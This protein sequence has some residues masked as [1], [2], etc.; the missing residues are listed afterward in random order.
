L[1]KVPLKYA[2][3]D[4]TELAISE[5]QERMA[6]VVTAADVESFLA[7]AS[8]ENLEAVAVAEVTSEA[9]LVLKWRGKKIVDLSRAFLDTNGARQ[10]AQVYV[11]IPS[12]SDN[13]KTVHGFNG[14]KTACSFN[15]WLSTLAALN[16]CSQKGLVEMFDSTIGCGTVTLPYGGRY[17]LSES[18]LMIAKLP[19]LNGRTSTVSLMSFGFNPYLTAWSPYHGAVYAVTEALA[20]LVAAGA[21]HD[22]ARFSFQE[23]FQRLNTDARRWSQP[24]A[25]LLGAFA[26]QRGFG[27][28]SLGG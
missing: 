8:E 28:P 14:V 20:R 12:G 11:E 6:V 15:A 17:Q 2:G 19:L 27:L 4:G 25:A 16:V 21:S 7:F 5:S 24:F 22:K 26:A 18:Q 13:V 10:E 23:Y 9:R 3:L 1:D